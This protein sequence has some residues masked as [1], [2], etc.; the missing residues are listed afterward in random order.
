MSR[1]LA[2]CN[3]YA[4]Y[5][6]RA[7]LS[8]DRDVSHCR[9]VLRMCRYTSRQAGTRGRYE[10]D[11]IACSLRRAGPGRHARA[12]ATE[13]RGSAGAVG[14]VVERR[15]FVME[16]KI[17]GRTAFQGTIAELSSFA[18][19]LHAATPL[20]LLARS[21]APLLDQAP[22]H[23]TQA[24]GVVPRDP[25]FGVGEPLLP[26]IAPKNSVGLTDFTPGVAKETNLVA[27]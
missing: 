16:E 23:C 24:V 18:A 11:W 5:L 13:G 21:A 15:V 3:L 27:R 17:V 8:L 12:D 20:A 22:Q 6:R 14:R 10:I 7:L 4:T 9:R 25:H 19:R 1:R 2:L 26:M